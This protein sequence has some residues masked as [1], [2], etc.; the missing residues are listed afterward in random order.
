MNASAPSDFIARIRAALPRMHPSERRL[1]EVV[2]NFPGEL[3]SY[4][5]TELAR[6]AN[7]S[8]ATVTRFVRKIGYAS[9]EEARQAAR[10]GQRAG[11]ALFRVAP[12]SQ[13]PDDVVAA[14]LAQAGANLDQ[15]FAA[16]TLEEIDALARAML[17]APRVWVAGMRA[18]QPVARYLG[19]Q[20]LQILPNVNVLPRDGETLAESI[21]SMEP[22]DCVIM[23]AL[24]RPVRDLPAVM[25]AI[26]Q[27]GVRLARIGD[28]DT[29]A[30]CEWDFACATG[31]PGP[32]FNHVAAMALCHM[33]ASR[34]IELA[35]QTGRARLM[36]IDTLHDSL[37]E[38]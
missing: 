19:W 24:R 26:G 16:I 12:D 31:A 9:F 21:A 38:L 33:L 15:T 25:E 1:A 14:H 36:R 23:I 7:V 3:A 6:L 8:N 13:R 27:R 28:I 30:G 37:G 20:V 17:A 22:G 32:L 10:A 5:A 11:A 18:A 29:D 35:G 4:S 2:L 34:V